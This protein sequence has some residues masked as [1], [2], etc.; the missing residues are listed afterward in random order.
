MN[1]PSYHINVPRNLI[2]LL[3]LYRKN[4]D[5]VLL[6]GGT[7]LMNHLLNREG[8]RHTVLALSQLDELKRISRT[9]RYAEA[10]C[11]VTINQMIEASYIFKFPLMQDTM[12][13]MGPYP[14]RNMSTL[15]GNICIPGRRMD[16]FPVLLLLDARAELR[17]VKP[18]R[19]GKMSMKSR[20]VSIASLLTPDGDLNLGEGEILTRIRIPYYDGNFTFHRKVN[21]R[22]D[23]YLTANCLAAI[24]K[25]VVSD[26]RLAF[27]NGGRLILRN[28]DLEANLLGRRFP[29][30]RKDADLLLGNLDHFFPPGE[31]SYETYLIRNLF[32]QLLESLADPQT[33]QIGN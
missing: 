31:S 2:D 32:R 26:I 11:C 28:R 13:E 4:P 25:G 24:E 6:A 8:E 14:I 16:L 10:G 19:K 17:H 7:H 12:A 1:Q 18:K 20:W 15:G 3:S 33:N 23:N 21:I 30:S 29:L 9:D 27:T 5:A 22:Q